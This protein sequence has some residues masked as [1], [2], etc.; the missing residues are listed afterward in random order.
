[1]C[2]GKKNP[3]QCRW[4]SIRCEQCG[5]YSLCLCPW[6]QQNN[7]PIPSLLPAQ[8][9]IWP[10]QSSKRNF[11]NWEAA[12]CQW[13]CWCCWGLGRPGWCLAAWP[14]LHRGAECRFQGQAPMWVSNSTCWSAGRAYQPGREQGNL[15]WH[16]CTC[17]GKSVED[18]LTEHWLE[19][20]PVLYLAPLLL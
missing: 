12:E 16:C 11:R 1:M 3:Q 9:P 8:G 7:F 17:T 14:V 18:S 5:K 13:S 4:S 20:H 6:K 19:L 15:F 10:G 2:F